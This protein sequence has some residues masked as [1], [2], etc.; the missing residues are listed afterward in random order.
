MDPIT[1]FIS[2]GPEALERVNIIQEIKERRLGLLN[3]RIATFVSHV[4]AGDAASDI[5]SKL[6]APEGSVLEINAKNELFQVGKVFDKSLEFILLLKEI[7]NGFF[8]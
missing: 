3:W 1:F 6:R 5:S 8:L 7:F 4:E 2:E